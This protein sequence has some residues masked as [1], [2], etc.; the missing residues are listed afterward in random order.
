MNHKI[1]DLFSRGLPNPIQD[2][3]PQASAL[4]KAIPNQVTSAIAAA[5]TAVSQTI[6]KFP[7]G[8]AAGIKSACLLQ[9]GG[10]DCS[11][12]TSLPL[13]IL[14]KAG[15]ALNI[16]STIA[17]VFRNWFSALKFLSFALSF[18][19]FVVLLAFA[20]FTLAIVALAKGI[21]QAGSAHT[22]TAFG[23]AIGDIAFSL[24]HVAVSFAS[25]WC[26]P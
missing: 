7:S 15:L 16:A 21:T 18:V 13:H 9:S 20:I 10:S 1:L 2:L 8:V 5:E 24:T 26:G 6:Q 23:A 4:G 22:G 19:G 11:K 25:L 12:S 17:Y 3:G 14:L